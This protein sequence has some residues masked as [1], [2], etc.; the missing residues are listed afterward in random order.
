MGRVGMVPTQF[1]DFGRVIDAAG[2]TPAI[3]SIAP[4]AAA[5]VRW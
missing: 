2:W 3:R 4:I 5:A 1:A